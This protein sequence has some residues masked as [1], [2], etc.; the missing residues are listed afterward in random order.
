MA[1]IAEA[2]SFGPYRFEASSGRL[3]RGGQELLLTPKAAAVLAVL[4]ARAGQLVSKQD[5]FATA[6][7]DTAVGDDALTSCIREL[8]RALGD[9]PKRPR[10]IET[11][12]RRGYRFMAALSPSARRDADR[13]AP[14]PTPAEGGGK[15]TV[16]V[17]PFENMSGDPDQGYFSDGV[18]EDIITALSRHRSL[19]VIARGPAFAFK[20]HPTDSRTVGARLGADYVVEGSVGKI[21]RRLRIRARLVESET[22]R[23]VWSEHYEREVDEVFDLRDEI[24]AAIA[25]RIEP[26]VGASERRRVEGRPAE[27]L[28]TWD[29]F[30]LGQVHFYRFTAEGNLEAQR[31]WRRA[32]ERGTRQAA[33]YASLSYAM[34]LSMI[35]FDADPADAYLSEAV[36]LARRSVELD[37]RDALAHFAHGRALLVRQAYQEALAVLQQAL[38]LNPCL[39]VVHCGLGD[40]LAYEGRFAE[41]I[42]HFERA[43]SLSPYDPQRWAFHS[44]RALAHLF[45]GDFELAQDWS[46]KATRMP[47][48]HY[49]AFAHRVSALGHLEQGAA[50]PLAKAELLERKGDFSRGFAR[51]RL[52]YVRNARDVELY[53]EGLR[54]AGI[55]E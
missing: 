17:L 19:L 5:L 39:A 54:K 50:L 2:V 37:D 35:Y 3:W 46:Q 51:R 30:H 21:G 47:N 40:S 49:W 28:D 43:I 41:A 27:D 10:F 23:Y 33:V 9:E 20:G 8:R 25:G 22:G 12:H 13:G 31:L 55:A 18:S 34:V 44:Y 24:T 11:R 32:I 38:E 29:L 53:V 42:P 26:E 45:A 14:R 7:A 16:V 52:F 36:A 48:C 6:W 1:A 4:I 15:P